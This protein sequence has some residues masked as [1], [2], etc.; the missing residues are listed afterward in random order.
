MLEGVKVHKF[1]ESRVRVESKLVFA[2]F[3]QFLSIYVMLPH[4]RLIFDV[5]FLWSHQSKVDRLVKQ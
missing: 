1:E 4:Q 5:K 3:A 2:V